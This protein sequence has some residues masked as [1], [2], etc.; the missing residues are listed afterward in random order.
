MGSCVPVRAPQ[1]YTVL[2]HFSPAFDMLRAGS[3]GL[4][5]YRLN[6]GRLRAVPSALGPPHAGSGFVFSA[7]FSNRLIENQDGLSQRDSHCD[8]CGS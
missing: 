7:E 1:D 3:S 5:R 4:I 2:G 6:P 8:S